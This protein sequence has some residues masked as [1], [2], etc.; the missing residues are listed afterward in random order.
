MTTLSAPITF[1]ITSAFDL[2][3]YIHKDLEEYNRL[4]IYFNSSTIK[5]SNDIIDLLLCIKTGLSVEDIITITTNTC[6]I[7]IY[8]NY[9]KKM[10]K[11]AYSK[12]NRVFSI[13]NMGQI[14][15]NLFGWA[16]QE[17]ADIQDKYV[18]QKNIEKYRYN[19]IDLTELADVKLCKEKIDINTQ[20]TN[21][22]KDTYLC[23]SYVEYRIN[24]DTVTC[25]VI[26][27]YLAESRIN[28]MLVCEVNEEKKVLPDK[29]KKIV[30][31]ANT[32]RYMITDKS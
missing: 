16:E 18:S 30:H 7:N 27:E 29:C 2:E 24:I 25:F 11:I 6:Y 21:L 1:D 26:R 12:Q 31:M 4:V 22:C 32:I 14:K 19:I 10:Q 28:I 8:D 13:R 17:D 9:V 20:C 3:K 23:E 5:T 15:S